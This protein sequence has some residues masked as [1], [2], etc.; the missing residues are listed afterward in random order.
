MHGGSEECYVLDGDLQVGVLPMERGDYQRVD[1]GSH[2]V[3][4]STTGGCVLFIRC[5]MSDELIGG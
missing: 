3:V 1:G 4:Q 2:H 5:S